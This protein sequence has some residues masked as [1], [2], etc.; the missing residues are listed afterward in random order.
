MSEFKGQLLG[1]IIV[2]GVFGAIGTVLYNA[3]ADSAAAIADKVESVD[4]T[5]LKPAPATGF[6]VDVTID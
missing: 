6:A 3:F 5:N 1:L 4:S 2:I